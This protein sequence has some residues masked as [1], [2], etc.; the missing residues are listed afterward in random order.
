MSLPIYNSD[1]HKNMNIFGL[2]IC[3]PSWIA[4]FVAQPH[5]SS[6]LSAMRKKVVLGF[7]LGLSTP[8]IAYAGVDL[9]FNTNDTPDPLPA[10]GVVTYSMTIANNGDAGATGVTSTHIIPANTTYLGFTGTGVACAGMAVNDPGPGTVTCTHPDI[11]SIAAPIPGVSSFAIQLRTAVSGS[12]VFGADASSAEAD[13]NAANNTDNEQTTVNAGANFSISKT[14]A[15]GSAAAGSAFSWTLAVSNAGPNAATHLRIQDPVPTGFS[16]TSL[17]AG[18][19]NNAGT[20]ICDIA[21]PIAA[22]GSQA[23]G[24]VTGVISAAS[25]STVT[26]SATVGLSPSATASDAADPDT[27][28]N[29][30]IS[31]ISISAG[32]DLKITKSRSVSGNLLVGTAFNFVLS[33]SYTGDS[34]S[35]ITVTDSI[36]SNYTIGAVPTPQ[37]GWACGVAGQV[38]TCTRPSGGVAGLNQSLG[39]ITIPVTV[40]SAGN[41]VSNSAS[42]TSA[43]P[44][45]PTPG[46]NTA[47]DGGV[48]LVNPTV[49]LGVSKTG[50]SPALVVAGVPFNFSIRA[51]NTGTTGF[52]G[53][54]VLTDN[55]PAGMTVTGYTL[56]GWSCSPVAPVTGPAAITCQRTYTSGAQLA[57]NGTTPAVVLTAQV[58]A[59]GAFSNS[60][61]ITTPNCNLGAGNCGD[62]DISIGAVLDNT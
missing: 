29:T 5:F 13:D 50:P 33:P 21:G 22:G 7:F 57:P 28:N 8:V 37:N 18:C 47:T 9:V 14:P 3:F 15:T 40:A 10:G 53:D 31:N 56:N 30:A 25:G 2:P 6:L 20:I 23:I 51:S 27:G 60:A 39:N 59:S 58:A 35:N 44:N 38:V 52:F 17:P 11:A 54:I 48:N 55:L 16:V 42:I 32:S 62:G 43:S 61:T 4:L 24:A 34:P 49:D 36:P 1:C 19:S 26:N 46:N 41:N 12:I 45:D